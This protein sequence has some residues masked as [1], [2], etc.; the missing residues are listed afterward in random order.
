MFVC[1][2][3]RPHVPKKN[4]LRAADQTLSIKS[5]RASKT[6][7]ELFASYLVLGTFNK[8]HV[9][10]FT[11]LHLN[12]SASADKREKGGPG[13]CEC[14]ASKAEGWRKDESFKISP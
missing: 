13:S 6:E 3:A 12:M 5:K 7:P 10:N 9:P 14:N 11:W 1:A 8:F 2:R 4:R